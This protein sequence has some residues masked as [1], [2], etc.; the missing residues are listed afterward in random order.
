MRDSITVTYTSGPVTCDLARVTGL[1]ALEYRLRTGENLDP[2]LKA[3]ALTEIPGD[4][5]P[6]A[7]RVLVV[8]LAV[9]QQVDVDA[10]LELV[11]ATVPMFPSAPPDEA[12]VV[13]APGNDD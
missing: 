13:G 2:A 3:L 12:G 10:S 9:R 4:D 11:A 7:D 5:L 8:W 6:A 1:D